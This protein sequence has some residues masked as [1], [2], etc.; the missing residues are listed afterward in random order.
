MTNCLIPRERFPFGGFYD[1]IEMILHEK[2]TMANPIEPGC[3]GG[4]EVQ[5]AFPIGSIHENRLLGALLTKCTSLFPNPKDGIL[6]GG[7]LLMQI[8]FTP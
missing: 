1:Q 7:L 6:P 8:G 2:V 3:D 4:R 5:E